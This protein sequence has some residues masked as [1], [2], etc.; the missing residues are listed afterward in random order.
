[1]YHPN[2]NNFFVLGSALVGEGDS[3]CAMGIHYVLSTTNRATY[4]YEPNTCLVCPA[5][6]MHGEYGWERHWACGVSELMDKEAPRCEKFLSING[7]NTIN[8]RYLQLRTLYYAMWGRRYHE[9][10]TLYR[11]HLIGSRSSTS[12]VPYR[13]SM[14]YA[15]TVIVYICERVDYG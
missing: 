1:M 13:D 8:I 2:S 3:E 6:A 10:V 15:T 12:D 4:S 9:R 5:E 7:N 14:C 11:T